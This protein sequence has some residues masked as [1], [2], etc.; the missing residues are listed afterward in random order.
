M[1]TLPPLPPN[2]PSP[3]QNNFWIIC[4]KI[5][6]PDRSTSVYTCEVR[7]VREL[8]LHLRMENARFPP[9][10]AAPRNLRVVGRWIG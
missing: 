3:S 7:C 2:I 9:E 4:S 8:F 1:C 5:I 10:A 6:D